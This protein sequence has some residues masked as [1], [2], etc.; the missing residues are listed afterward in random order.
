MSHTTTTLTPITFAPNFKGFYEDAYLLPYRDLF[1]SEA[2]AL[3]G[4]QLD[5]CL[6]EMDQKE[7]EIVKLESEELNACAYK[8]PIGRIAGLFALIFA[9]VMAGVFWRG[10]VSSHYSL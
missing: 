2:D 1:A 5:P 7:Y 9:G 4:Q 8:S 6:V 10:K 3:R